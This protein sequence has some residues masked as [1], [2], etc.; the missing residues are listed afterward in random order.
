MDVLT[1]Q[2]VEHDGGRATIKDAILDNINGARKSVH[3]E[4]FCLT[5]KEVVQSLKDAHNRGVDVKVML[6]PN[7]YIINRKAFY[8][9]KDAGV[10]VKW[11]VPDV[12][13]EEKLHGKWA[14]IDGQRTIV[15]S[16]NWSHKGLE[17]GKPGDRTNREAN[18]L[19]RDENTTNI[20]NETFNYDWNNRGSVKVPDHMRFG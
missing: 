12:S 18:V 13:K 9:L 20:F 15:G 11:Y 19:V 4:L 6:D 10:P 7:L 14:T 8:D 1:T 3:A 5:H 2:P 17:G 16:A